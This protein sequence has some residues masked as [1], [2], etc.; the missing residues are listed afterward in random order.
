MSVNN[1]KNLS[2]M[3]ARPERS[4]IEDRGEGD[5]TMKIMHS[6]LRKGAV[7]L[8]IENTDDL[9]YLSTVL[10]AGDL[11]KGATIRKIKLGESTDRKV[12]IVKKTVFLEI[13]IERIEFEIGSKTLRLS[14]I[15]T[16]GPDDIARGSH[17]TIAVEEH[18]EITIQKQW[19]QFQLDKLKEA[20]EEKKPDVLI[21]VHDR[22][23]A[24]IAVLRR[25]GY[26]LLTKIAGNVTKKAEA[27]MHTSNFYKEIIALM[28]EYDQRYHPSTIIV[29]SPSFWKED[30][31]KNLESEHEHLRKK[32]VLATCSSCDETAIAEILKR[33]E[34]KSVLK[35]Q[36]IAQEIQAVEELMVEIAK[37]SLGVYGYKEV[38]ERVVAGAVAKLL[39]TD[40]FIQKTKEAGKYQE[41]DNLMKTVDQGKGNI[42]II[43][44]E[45]EGGKKLD[46]LGG[47][48][49]MVR[50]KMRY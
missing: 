48:A 16:Q 35:Q 31:M 6:D 29:A 38:E 2:A 47:I 40:G 14:G 46:G 30:L 20:C 50:Y 28:V 12:E 42:M 21:V 33:Q 18:S 11:V 17:H 1:D 3:D 41:I 34:V 9:W 39:V 37:E 44:S 43:S 4:E 22:E 24:Y 36:K 26:T 49:A 23:E 19:M 32:I 27:S 7:K 13:K 15:I 45:H 5:K 10:D 25:Y 8:K